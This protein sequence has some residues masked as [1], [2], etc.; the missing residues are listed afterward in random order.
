M[1]DGN[2]HGQVGVQRLDI[3]V[4]LRDGTEPGGVI[5][6]T[7]SERRE[8]QRGGSVLGYQLFSRTLKVI[9]L[10]R[11]RWMAEIFVLS[12]HAEDLYCKSNEDR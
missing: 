2:S 4:D 5:P 3:K 1:K 12:W 10:D 8:G 9:S 11:S 6:H 7:R